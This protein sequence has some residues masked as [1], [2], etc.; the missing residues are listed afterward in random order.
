MRTVITIYIKNCTDCNHYKASNTKPTGHLQIPI[1]YRQFEILDIGLR[2]D[3]L[4]GSESNPLVREETGSMTS[5]GS[6]RI[7][8]FH[9]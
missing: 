4:D 1:Y 9:E 8:Y 3:P 7:H 6:L 5:G 2:G